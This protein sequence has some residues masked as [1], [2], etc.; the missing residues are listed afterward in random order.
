MLY[1]LNDR[2]ISGFDLAGYC[3]RE[4]NAAS[5]D[6]A[7]AGNGL[8]WAPAAERDERSRPDRGGA[9]LP[10]YL[11][12]F[13]DLHNAR[14]GIET[15]QAADDARAGQTAANLIRQTPHYHAIEVWEADRLVSRHSATAMPGAVKLLGDSA[16]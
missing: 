12:Y 1:A 16:S 2:A 10:A 13:L 6:W 4:L 9:F 8:F 7:I 11:C 14:L 3:S 5:L 15:I